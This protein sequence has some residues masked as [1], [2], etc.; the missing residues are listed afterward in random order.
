MV[1]KE[2]SQSGAKSAGDMIPWIISQQV[3]DCLGFS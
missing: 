3:S 2:L 1:L